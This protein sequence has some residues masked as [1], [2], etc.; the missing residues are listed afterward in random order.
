MR[1]LARIEIVSHTRLVT[2]FAKL[3]RAA[4]NQNI[5]LASVNLSPFRG[6]NQSI[7]EQALQNKKPLWASGLKNPNNY[8]YGEGNYNMGLPAKQFN[9]IELLDAIRTVTDLVQADLIRLK[10]PISKEYAENAQ[11]WLDKRKPRL[12]ELMAEYLRRNQS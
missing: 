6:S 2:K 12:L 3:G 11:Y 9:D 1:G 4:F 5:G 10:N 8:L 7:N